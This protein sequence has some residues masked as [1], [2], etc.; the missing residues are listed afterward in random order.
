M[1]PQTSLIIFPLGV[2]R[3]IQ[4]GHYLSVHRSSTGDH[5]SPPFVNFTARFDHYNRVITET[6]KHRL[7][8]TDIMLM[9]KKHFM[10]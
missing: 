8:S 4:L 3:Q 2:K 9:K 6:I 5:L 7:N 1:K 10:K